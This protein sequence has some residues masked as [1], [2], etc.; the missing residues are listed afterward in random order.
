[1]F[2]YILKARRKIFHTISIWYNLQNFLDWAWLL[3]SEIPTA[4][5]AEIGLWFK[6]SSCKKLM[7]PYLKN[8]LGM[9][10]YICNPSFVGG[11]GSRNMV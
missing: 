1:M 8:K 10:G 3:K 6:A 7:R 4:W 11:L 2:I 9:V 5:K